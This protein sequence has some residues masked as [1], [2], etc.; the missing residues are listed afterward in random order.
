MPDESSPS[1]PDGATLALAAGA[2]VAL[3]LAFWILARQFAVETRIGGHLPSAFASFALLLA[4]YWFFGFGLAEVLGRELRNR[5]A[6]VLAPALLLLPYLLYS[7][8][9]GEFRPHQAA[10]LVVVPVG[11]AA[12][13]EILPPDRR[14]GLGWQDVVALAAV[15]LPVELRWLDWL[16]PHPGLSFLPKALLLDA[17]LYAFLVV[18]RTEGVGFDFRVRLRDLAVGLREWAFFAPLGIGLGLAMHFIQPRAWLPGAGTIAGG[19]LITLFF[20]AIPE[21]FFFRG[22]LQN[23]LQKRTGRIRALAITAALFGLSHFNK[24][25]P[26]NWRYVLLA[27][28]AG[29]FYGRAW[30]DRQRLMASAIT[31]TAVDVVWSLWFRG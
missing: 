13:F 3:L 8:P 28:I 19:C 20:V 25:A 7:V 23:L 11:L 9:R 6:R 1:R 4:P 15:G 24:P 12:L 31:H 18:R 14:L 17:A 21:E 30:L 22:L 10:I 27:A 2:Y 26:F 5:V 16:W 29:V